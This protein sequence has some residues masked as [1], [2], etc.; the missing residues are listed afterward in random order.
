MLLGPPTLSC[1]RTS[2]TSVTGNVKDILATFIGAAAFNDFTPTT[3]SV[4]GI[5]VSFVG[6]AGFS[7][8]KLAE[9]QATKPVLP[10]AAPANPGR[11]ASGAV[12]REEPAEEGSVGSSRAVVIGPATERRNSRSLST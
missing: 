1:V 8:Q 5:A 4:S 10:V 9:M 2:A 11:A 7:W 6:A 3:Y 12:K